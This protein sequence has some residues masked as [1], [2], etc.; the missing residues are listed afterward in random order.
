MGRRNDE[1]QEFFETE[2]PRLYRLAY[3]LS[4]NV[5]HA[6]DLAQEAMT[7]TFGAWNR[8]RD[9][10]HPAAYARTTLIN[11]WRSQLR[12]R[13]VERSHPAEAST[14]Q[15]PSP[16]EHLALWLRILHLPSAQ[17]AA[18]VLRYYEDRTE[19]ETAAILGCPVGTVKSHVRR[20]LEAL[21]ETLTDI[22]IGPMEEVGE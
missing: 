1:F 19:A 6:E 7:R 5:S 8:I 2:F 18:I 4:G 20:G 17:R 9:R 22:E 21:R 12:R 15:E 10:E 14:L 11:Q 13:K 16:D 3:L